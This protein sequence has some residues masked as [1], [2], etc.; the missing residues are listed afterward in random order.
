ML[1]RFAQEKLFLVA[2]LGSALNASWIGSQ[3]VDIDKWLLQRPQVEEWQ[4]HQLRSQLRSKGEFSQQSNNTRPFSPT[5]PRYPI[6]DLISVGFKTRFDLVKAQNS[7][8]GQHSSVRNFFAFTE[9]DDN[10]DQCHTNL[11][12]ESAQFVSR[13]CRRSNHTR[14]MQK[15]RSRFARVAFL[16]KKENPTGWL[17]AQ[18]RPAESL[19]RVLDGYRQ[20]RHV[21]MVEGREEGL[22]QNVYP[23][24]LLLLDDDTYLNMMEIT[25]VLPELYPSHQ[26]Y[27][28]AGCMVR[29]RV[30]QHNFTFPWGGFGT[31]FS[32]ALVAKFLLP[33]HCHPDDEKRDLSVISTT[34]QE[35]SHEEFELLACQRIAQDILGE[36][37]L[38]RRGMSVA[39]LMYQFVTH[40]QY[41]NA[42][43]KWGPKGGPG[44]C[45]HADWVLG[46]FVNTYY[47]GQHTGDDF[48]RNH[49]EDRFRGWQGSNAYAGVITEKTRRDRKQCNHDGDDKC[50]PESHFCH[51]VTPQKMTA[52]YELHS[53]VITT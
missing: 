41:T 15:F 37:F 10:E 44:F 5:K 33:L 24:Y 52:M 49:A 35:L 29:E 1:S 12:I 45:M 22:V 7:T 27:A 14:E 30:A 46:Y 51:H 4:Q 39:D 28:I 43:E 53:E 36:K 48:Y 20:R 50:V 32:K 16:E 34:P 40:W 38:F 42:E 2:V 47:L 11:T 6:L 19:Y 17:C 26:S 3:K 18:K 13:F 25:K 23:D 21:M 31:I 9:D 8:F